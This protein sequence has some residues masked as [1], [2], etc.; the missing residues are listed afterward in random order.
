[1]VRRLLYPRAV[2]TASSSVLALACALAAGGCILHLG[3][4][5]DTKCPALADG[6][7]GAPAGTSLLDPGDLVCKEV[8]FGGGCG[9]PEDVPTWADCQTQ[10]TGLSSDACAAAPGCRQAWDEICL[11]TDAICTLP[12]P[13]YGCFAVDKTGPVQGSCANLDAEE[14]S[15]HDDCMGTYRRD[16]RCG[17]QTDDD[18]DGIVDEPDECLSFGTCVEE[19]R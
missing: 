3:D 14:C 6:T 5:D 10:C 16:E 2:R 12:D 4:D 15:R 17:N 18:F 9:I 8:F 19:F 11:L 7:A 13:Y 1:M